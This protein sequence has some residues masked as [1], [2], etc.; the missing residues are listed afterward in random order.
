M[1]NCTALP[2]PNELL[3]EGHHS[4]YGEPWAGGREFLADASHLRSEARV[5][6]VGWRGR[7]LNVASI[8]VFLVGDLPE[9]GS[10]DGGT[11]S[12]SF[13]ICLYGGGREV[14]ICL[15]S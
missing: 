5:L 13:G 3:V 6:E 8:W 10:S 11:F 14:R 12:S 15:A 1:K 4:N 9:Y 2:C 7:K